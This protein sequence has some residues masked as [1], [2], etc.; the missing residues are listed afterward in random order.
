MD[1][2]DDLMSLYLVDFLWLL[3]GHLRRRASNS[4]SL[5]SKFA[6]RENEGDDERDE[7]RILNR[8]REV[9]IKRNEN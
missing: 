7:E 1:D 5:S 9:E 6:W 2:D 3:K 8:K 4:V